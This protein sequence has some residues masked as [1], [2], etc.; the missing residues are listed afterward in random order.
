MVPM[1]KLCFYTLKISVGLADLSHMSRLIK[2][3]QSGKI[4]LRP[5]ITHV[6]P[7]AQALDGYEIF[8]KRKDTCIK[9]VLKP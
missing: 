2:L 3:V 4:N 1:E 6:F 5:L 9:V 8:E 7:L